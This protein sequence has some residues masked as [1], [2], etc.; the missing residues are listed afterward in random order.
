MKPL[1]PESKYFPTIVQ[2][3]RFNEAGSREKRLS[4]AANKIWPKY[5]VP[6]LR[7]VPSNFFFSLK[8]FTK[9]YMK[10]ALNRY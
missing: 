10:T 9:P 1:I 2:Q 6:L 5:N 4:A 3:I 7:R 8:Y